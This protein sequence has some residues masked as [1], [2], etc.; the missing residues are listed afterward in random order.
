M[1]SKPTHQNLYRHEILEKTAISKIQQY[2]PPEG[3]YL[4]FSGRKDSS[5]IYDL[6]VRAGVKFDAHFSRTTVD[7]PEVLKFIKE[8]YPDVIWEKPRMSMFELIR[9]NKA[10]PTRI[11]R[12]CCAALKEIGGPGRTILTGIRW[13]ESVRRR[14]RRIFEE[15]Y[16]RK[17]TYF[18]NTIIGWSTDDVWRYIRY[19]KMP[20]C[21]LYDEGA[22]RIGCIMCP[23]KSPKAM[24]FDA[25][26][27]P[28][29]YRAY[30]RAI[31]DIMKV[32]K[33]K[34]NTP[35][36]MMNWWINER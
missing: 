23:M 7:P 33:Y 2:E 9:K 13:E 16:K 29:Y 1:I 19:R 5:V 3:Y 15:S 10:L 24:K 34:W 21:S 26:K 8:N 28:K 18:L 20:Y 11:M 30:L 32:K 27:Y 36:E 14:K 4:A 12:F 6:A 25:E 35:E 31:R 17:G 22:E